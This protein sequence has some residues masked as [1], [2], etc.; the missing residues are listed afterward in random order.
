VTARLALTPGEPAGIGPDLTV[1]LAQ[2]AYPFELIAIADPDLL[3]TRA[4]DRG[5][6]IQI[7]TVS[8]EELAEPNRTRQPS[9]ANQLTVLPV[10]T[11]G[12]VT[13][14]EL[15]TANARYVLTTLETAV[16]GCINEWFDAMVTGPV[17]KGVI[18]DAGIAFTGHTEFLAEHTGGEP[19]MLLTAEEVATPL[20]VALAT[21]HLP[22]AK[23]A[24]ALTAERI[25]QCLTTLR[26]PT[27]PGQRS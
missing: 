24:D 21:T 27:H 4:R 3:A 15:S 6:K 2:S 25:V 12:V 5:L 13:P 7:D 26:S 11:D 16:T 22:L 23:V 8:A 14:G 17:H 10:S 20:R 18:N 19:L 1:L 9:T